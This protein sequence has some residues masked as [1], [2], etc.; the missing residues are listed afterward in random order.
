MIIYGSCE[1]AACRGQSSVMTSIAVR[2]SGH[3]LVSFPQ[4]CAL[5]TAHSLH[6][7]IEHVLL[8]RDDMT[9]EEAIAL[10]AKA[11]RSGIFN[12][13]GSGS[14]VDLCV[15]SEG[16]KKV[17]YLR[18]YEKLQGRTY[19]RKEPVIFQ[20]G[21]A[22]AF[23]SAAVAHLSIA[24]R[25]VQIVYHFA[26]APGISPSPSARHSMPA[27]LACNYACVCLWLQR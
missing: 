24:L 22:R 13:L 1:A 2:G 10:V 19:A 4:P 18:N 15:I 8:C 5:S 3:W 20:K 7:A 14:N 9:R 25:L 26:S 21:T 11:I 23:L 12:D 6:A 17:D 27:S 16:G